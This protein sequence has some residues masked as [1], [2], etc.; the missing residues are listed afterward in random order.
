[1]SQHL[2]ATTTSP[3][4]GR[5]KPSREPPP[6]YTDPNPT[7]IVD[8]RTPLILVPATTGFPEERVNRSRRA[9]SN[10][11]T[12][13]SYIQ[14]PL[15]PTAGTNHVLE[16]STSTIASDLP[17]TTRVERYFDPLK[18]QDCWMALLHL[19]VINFPFALV[20]WVYLFVAT[21]VGTTLLLTLPFGVLIWWA[22]LRGARAFTRWELI[23]QSKFH[24]IADG[25]HLQRV[26]YVYQPFHPSPEHQSYMYS[27]SPLITP[28]HLES[29]TSETG[30]STS[31]PPPAYEGS[32]LQNTYA[33]VSGM[34]SLFVDAAGSHVICTVP[35]PIFL[36]TT[37]LLPR[38]QSNNNTPVDSTRP[39]I[40]PCIISIGLSGSIHVKNGEAN[41]EM[42]G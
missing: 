26:P 3:R 24:K 5:H 35:G 34:M 9:A 31:A 13:S 21:L 8:E 16:F 25:A 12:T 39:S 23:L 10:A 40:C 4:Q 19:G 37:F 42:A 36:P 22:N 7:L 28:A 20:A 32:F 29:A 14:Q 41:G 30:N 38:D 15:S 11:T 1:M 18:D 27:H 33:M 17:V 2:P 6:P